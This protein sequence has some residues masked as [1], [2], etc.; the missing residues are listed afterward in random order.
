MARPRALE[1]AIAAPVDAARFSVASGDDPAHQ[2]ANTSPAMPALPSPPPRF[3]GPDAV[4]DVTETVASSAIEATRPGRPTTSTRSRALV[5]RIL[6]KRVPAPMRIRTTAPI[7]VAAIV[8]LGLYPHSTPWIPRASS[9]H[10]CVTPAASNLRTGE[11]LHRAQR[12]PASAPGDPQ[13]ELMPLAFTP[14]PRS[15]LCARERHPTGARRCS[16]S[17][18]SIFCPSSSRQR[19]STRLVSSALR[20]VK[21]LFDPMYSG[22]GVLVASWN[23]FMITT[24][25]MGQ[26]PSLGQ[27]LPAIAFLFR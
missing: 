25:S 22:L 9:Q 11:T 26:P 14:S 3:T 2:C 4:V 17:A 6:A 20:P 8:A 5:S 7:D 19:C 21:K 18:F 27:T 1:A 12:L 15:V 10:M 23:M 16:A 24:P 13:H